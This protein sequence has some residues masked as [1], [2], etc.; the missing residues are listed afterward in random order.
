MKKCPYC[1][2]T[3]SN[4]ELYCLGCGG[5]LYDVSTNDTKVEHYEDKEEDVRKKHRAKREEDTKSFSHNALAVGMGIVL[6]IFVLIIG[7][8]SLWQKDMNTDYEAGQEVN[9]VDISENASIDVNEI[10]ISQDG[11]IVQED[12]QHEE[13]GIYEAENVNDVPTVPE[14]NVNTEV[15]KP[16]IS[17]GKIEKKKVY[18]GSDIEVTVLGLTRKDSSDYFDLPGVVMDKVA[19]TVEIFNKGKGEREFDLNHWVVLINDSITVSAQLDVTIKAGEKAT[20]DIEIDTEYLNDIGIW[21]IGDIKFQ[22]CSMEWKD[23]VGTID[24][25]TEFMD[26]PTSMYDKGEKELKALSVDNVQE[27]YQANG[28]SI[29]GRYVYSYVDYDRYERTGILMLVDNKSNQ[30]IE[31]AVKNIGIDGR[32]LGWGSMSV[33]PSAVIRNSKTIA[34]YDVSQASYENID[35][36]NVNEISFSIDIFGLDGDRFHTIDE[37][38]TIMLMG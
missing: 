1:G 18:D 25:I 14:E 37:T 7:R 15:E 19:L 28:I 3:N 4:N 16:S 8:S 35:T 27:I 22:I 2:K 11:S 20:A 12:S 31:I 10:T 6:V 17:T 29:T 36:E 26:V 13:V 24:K 23:G 38:D 5:P 32:E 34:F 33:S 21:T 9:T 30:D